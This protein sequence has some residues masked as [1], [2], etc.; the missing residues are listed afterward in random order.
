MSDATVKAL[1]KA[2]QKVGKTLADDMGKAAKKMYKQA[3]DNLNKTA[4]HHKEND[5]HTADD[6]DG[7]AKDKAAEPP[8]TGNGAGGDGAKPAPRKYFIH[9]DG[10]VQEIKNGQL[11]DV[12]DPD[13]SLKTMLDGTKVKDPSKEEIDKHNAKKYK[14]SDKDDDGNQK[15]D[16]KVVSQKID[17]PTE[18]SRAVEEARRAQGDYGGKNY[19]SLRYRDEK[20]EFILV[21]RSDYNR[22]HSE[23][24]I[25]KPL[26]GGREGNVT[27]LYTERA[28]CQAGPNCERW[29]AR[30]FE[31]QNPDLK[32][33][34]G[35]DYDNKVPTKDRDWAHKAY[36]KQ[37]EQD[38][39]AGQH[40]GTMGTK[41]FDAQ[42]QQ[43]KA[44]S[45]AK[46]KAKGL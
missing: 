7:K 41:D 19:A 43:D 26:L 17:D 39:A 9:D 45:A 4:K 33:T 40:G 3:G 10:R 12:K 15:Q 25:G 38:H 18:L 14:K 20:G 13:E 2:A 24:S 32:V 34:H 8:K 21:G 44:A 5:H 30:H 27:D 46:K 6:F 22:S 31:S 11:V 23:R 1:Q 36:L 35:V 29:L 28:P 42:G 37:I 16:E